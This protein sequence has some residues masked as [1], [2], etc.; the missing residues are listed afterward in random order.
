MLML[1]CHCKGVCS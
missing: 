1:A